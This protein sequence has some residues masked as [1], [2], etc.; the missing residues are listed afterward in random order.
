[1]SGLIG[2]TC[3][4]CGDGKLGEEIRDQEYKYQGHTL[5]IQQ[6]GIYCSHCDEAIFEPAHLKS[7]RIDLQAFRAR[8]DG[9]LGPGEIK[10]IRIRIGLN[11]KE[12]GEVF[13]GGKNAFSRYEQG[14]VSPP[15]AVSLLLSLIGKH[16]ELRK[17][18][19]PAEMMA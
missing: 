4:F 17:E 9:L 18:I 19:I 13:G 6:P 10:K 3:P 2:D 16:P 15:K 11:Q 8:V 1:M 14:E 12:A 5:L 7:N